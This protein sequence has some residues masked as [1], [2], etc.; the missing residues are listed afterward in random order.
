M[1]RYMVRY[2]CGV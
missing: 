1:K 2:R